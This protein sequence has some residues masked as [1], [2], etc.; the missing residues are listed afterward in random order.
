MRVMFTD[1]MESE[2]VINEFDSIVLTRDIVGWFPELKTK[3]EELRDRITLDCVSGGE[4]TILV[5]KREFE[6]QTFRDCY[7]VLEKGF[8]DATQ[9]YIGI[10]NPTVDD[11]IYLGKAGEL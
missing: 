10:I 6:N 1:S 5:A 3:N 8:L 4:H 2:V 7:Q 11:I 9:K